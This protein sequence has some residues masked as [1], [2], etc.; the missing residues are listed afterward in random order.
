MAT[1]ARLAAESNCL[2]LSWVSSHSLSNLLF[3]C[4]GT[5][6]VVGGWESVEVDRGG[7]SRSGRCLLFDGRAVGDEGGVNLLPGQRSSVHGFVQ[8]HTAAPV[9]TGPWSNTIVDGITVVA[10]R[11]GRR[12]GIAGGLLTRPGR[13]WSPWK[14]HIPWSLLLL[15][16]L[17]CWDV[18]PTIVGVVAGHRARVMWM[19]QSSRGVDSRTL[20]SRAMVVVEVGWGDEVSGV[21]RLLVVVVRV[22]VHGVQSRWI[23]Q[24]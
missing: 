3:L 22:A 24:G 2:G 20:E 18:G 10:E 9:S 13:S 17:G 7:E 15:W 8:V 14:G 21:E 23:A 5:N 6:L 1:E 16:L 4:P 11:E 19:G 12:G